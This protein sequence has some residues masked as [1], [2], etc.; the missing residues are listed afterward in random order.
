M[1]LITC[2]RLWFVSPFLISSIIIIII[3]ITGW[4]DVCLISGVKQII[5]ISLFLIVVLQL[6]RPF[7]IHLM[8]PSGLFTAFLLIIFTLIIL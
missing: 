8:L 4:T 5:T 7:Y 2:Q 1:C 6:Q 3:I